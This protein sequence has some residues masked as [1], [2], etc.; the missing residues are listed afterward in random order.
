MF[1]L[2]QAAFEMLVSP[3][4]IEQ[5]KCWILTTN[6]Q[7]IPLEI[8]FKSFFCLCCRLFF[9]LQLGMHVSVYVCVCVCVIF[10]FLSCVIS[11][12]WTT[13]WRAWKRLQPKGQYFY[14]ICSE[15]QK[16][17]LFC[18]LSRT[19]RDFLIPINFIALTLSGF[20]L[21]KC[22]LNYLFYLWCAGS[23]LLSRLFSSCGKLGLHSSFC[24]QASQCNGFWCCGAQAL[25]WL[26]HVGSV[27]VPPGL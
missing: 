10:P 4:G 26:Q 7:G 21:K 23:S 12:P 15:S 19:R 17:K 11:V 22:F 27:T 8:G 5:W 1:W 16:W 6:C 3:L 25:L 13:V 9:I 20:L 14:I 2:H 18:S 24:G